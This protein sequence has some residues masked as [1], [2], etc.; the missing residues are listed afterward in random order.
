MSIV[1]C[2]SADICKACVTESLYTLIT[3]LLCIH[4]NFFARAIIDYPQNPMASP[5]AASFIGA[6]E[7][8]DDVLKILYDYIDFILPVLLRIWPYWSHMLAAAVRIHDLK[9]RGMFTL[10][11]SVDCMRIHSPSM[12]GLWFGTTRIQDT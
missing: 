7:A 1:I 4:R 5:F 2:V 8:A 3:V 10:T 6:F 12:P 11:S 9:V